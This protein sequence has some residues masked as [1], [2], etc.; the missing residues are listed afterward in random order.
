MEHG[1]VLILNAPLCKFQCDMLV[2][3]L[4]TVLLKTDC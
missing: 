1:N 2:A 3:C 4:W